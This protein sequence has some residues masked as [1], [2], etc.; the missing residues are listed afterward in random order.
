MYKEITDLEHLKIAF[1]AVKKNRGSAGI[2]NVSIAV[3]K[4]NLENNLEILQSR[5][6]ARKY[7]PKPVKRVY[8]DK[9]DGSQR[10]LGIPTVE[11]R[12]VQQAIKLVIEPSFEKQFADCSYGFRPKRSAHM[13]VSKVREKLS[14]A[15]GP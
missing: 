13:A 1:K 5:L 9:E 12:I 14:S 2:D 3:Y 8:I 10:P 11:D 15:S 4:E 7:V 6:I